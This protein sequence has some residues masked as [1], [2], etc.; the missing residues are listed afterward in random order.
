[1]TPGR[2]HEIARG[3]YGA[4]F[5]TD[6]YGP[7]ARKALDDAILAACR[8]ERRAALTWAVMMVHDMHREMGVVLPYNTVIHR[9]ES[10]RDAE[11]RSP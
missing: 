2:A 8:E 1:M 10:E 3:I 5:G 7:S 4:I 6:V 9:L 11:G